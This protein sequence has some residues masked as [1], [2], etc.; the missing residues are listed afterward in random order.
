[1]ITRPFSLAILLLLVCAGCAPVPNMRGP[2]TLD[3]RYENLLRDWT[4]SGQVF[5]ALDLILVTHATYL[6]P[7]FRQSFGE[8]YLQIFGIDPGR[9]DSDLEKIAT[10]VGRGHEFFLFLDTTQTEWNNLDERDSVWRLGLWGGPNQPGVPPLSVQGFQGRGPNLRAF[11]PFLTRFGRPYLV[12]FPIDQP[13]GKPV[14]DPENGVLTL[15]LASA[16]GTASLTWKVP[17]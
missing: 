13:N 7:G 1:M 17:E 14:L 16:L 4:R 10:S 6:S 2:K 5:Q 11:F 9:M 15:R 3:E 8:Q 12:V